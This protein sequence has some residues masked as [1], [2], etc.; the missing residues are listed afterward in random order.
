MA[1]RKRDFPDTSLKTLILWAKRSDIFSM[2]ERERIEAEI[3]ERQKEL[4]QWRMM[5]KLTKRTR[6]I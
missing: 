3:A 6:G 4:Q 1:K 5:K 2:K